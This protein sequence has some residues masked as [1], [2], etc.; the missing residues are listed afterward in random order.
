LL[1]FTIALL[2]FK[3]ALLLLYS[4]LKPSSYYYE[5]STAKKIAHVKRKLSLLSLTFHLRCV[6]FL[7]IRKLLIPAKEGYGAGGFPEWGIPPNGSLDF[8]IEVL[9]IK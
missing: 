9:Q 7:Q 2:G 8:E 5:S 1:S 3:A 4:A 6:S